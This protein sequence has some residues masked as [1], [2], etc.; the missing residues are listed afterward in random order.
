MT[1]DLFKLQNIRWNCFFLYNE[2]YFHL[3]A[4]NGTSS[5]IYNLYRLYTCFPFRIIKRCTCLHWFR[6]FIIMLNTPKP[7][8]PANWCHTLAQSSFYRSATRKLTIRETLWLMCWGPVKWC[9]PP[10]DW[11]NAFAQTANTQRYTKPHRH[12]HKRCD[13]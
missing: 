12:S 5:S 8:S 10:N 4:Y 2:N 11:F 9:S 7:V 6:L 13:D 3:L 1:L